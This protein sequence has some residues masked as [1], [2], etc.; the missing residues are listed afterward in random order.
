MHKYD[1]Q[2]KE[3]VDRCRR[4]ETRVTKFME[5]QG[6]D[7]KVRRPEWHDDGSIVVPSLACSIRDCLAAVPPWWD[8]DTEINVIHQD[9]IVMQFY[10]DGEVKEDDAEQTQ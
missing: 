2:I 7:T 1:E 10:P 9:K 4:I 3:V 5:A 6:F 8:K